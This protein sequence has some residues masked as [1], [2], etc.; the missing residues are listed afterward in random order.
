MSY[1]QPSKKPAK[2]GPAELS[3]MVEIHKNQPDLKKSG[4]S[5]IVNICRKGDVKVAVTIKE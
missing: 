2:E 4:W 3:E 1:H 5:P